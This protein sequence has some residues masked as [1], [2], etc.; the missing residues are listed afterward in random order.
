[1]E[2]AIDHGLHEVMTHRP[3]GSSEY[4]ALDDKL[5]EMRDHEQPEGPETDRRQQ[6]GREKHGQHCTNPNYPDALF[7]HKRMLA[8]WGHVFTSAS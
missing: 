7:L 2:E 3:T 8:A 6:S 1:M 4:V 5:R